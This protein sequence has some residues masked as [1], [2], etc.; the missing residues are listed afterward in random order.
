MTSGE[1]ILKQRKRKKLTQKELS[2]K[3]GVAIGTIRQYESGRRQPRLEQLKRLA[4]ALNV[5]LGFLIS[6]DDFFNDKVT[7]DVVEATIDDYVFR[8]ALDEHEQKV[9]DSL[10][11]ISN[12]IAE[13]PATELFEMAIAVK[14]LSP[15]DIHWLVVK[16]FPSLKKSQG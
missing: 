6:K 12:K 3:S 2:L 7:N 14:N 8:E 5:P 11:L 13:L 15:F 1:C 10:K 4:Y 16:H 9:A